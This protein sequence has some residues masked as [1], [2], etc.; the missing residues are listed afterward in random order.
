MSDPPYNIDDPRNVSSFINQMKGTKDSAQ[1]G[2]AANGEDATVKAAQLEMAGNDVAVVSLKRGVA[3][4]Y[5]APS[6]SN[7]KQTQQAPDPVAQLLVAT[8]SALEKSTAP[9]TSVDV[10]APNTEVTAFD[11]L[12]EARLAILKTIEKSKLNLEDSKYA[13][14]NYNKSFAGPA[15]PTRDAPGT[16][17]YSNRFS[18]LGA[19][20]TEM[21]PS[22]R[23][24]PK[25]IAKF[26]KEKTSTCQATFPWN[27]VC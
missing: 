5:D 10:A 9:A 7:M 20:Q 24:Q 13:P 21:S 4:Y 22:T 11:P 8:S 1:P 15:T 23:S 14:K 26:I 2:P 16:L 27:D 17:F 18:P 19:N 25:V 12:E 3:V 6:L